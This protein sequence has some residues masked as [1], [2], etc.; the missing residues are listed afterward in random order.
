MKI[1]TIQYGDYYAKINVSL[2]AN[3]I[4]L[5]NHKYNAQIL[6]VPDYN[7]LDNPYLYGMPILFPVNR[8]LGGYFEFEGR[9][10]AFPINESNT[11][12]AL[13]GDLHRTEFDMIFKS[14]NKIICRYRA[15]EYTPYLNFPHAFEIEISYELNEEGFWQK[16]I[17]RNLSEENMPVMIGFHTTFQV[18]FISGTEIKDINVYADVSEEYERNMSNYLPTGKILPSDGI[19][20]E[21]LEGRYVPDHKLSRH[22]RAGKPGTMAIIDQK[23][24]CKVIYENDEKFGFRLIYS[25]GSGFICLEP[26]NCMANAVN[27][28][29]DREFSGFDHIEPGKEKCYCSHIYISEM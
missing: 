5:S 25:E 20:N 16:T 10:Y 19:S 15:D 1:V 12:C 13:H 3:C 17:V 21:F 14:E 2:G 9:T 18:P 11:N 24:H 29:F 27:S 23:N 6:R 22:Y 8:I 7:R 4:Q 26:Q 28:P